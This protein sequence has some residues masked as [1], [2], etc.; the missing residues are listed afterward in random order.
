M[1]PIAFH[2]AS[3]D[4]FFSGSAFWF[5]AIVGQV[6]DSFWIKR[7]RRLAAILGTLLI[8]LSSTPIPMIPLLLFLLVG[9]SS[10]LLCSPNTTQK[11]IAV[12]T[13]LMISLFIVGSE[14]RYRF[15]WSVQEVSGNRLVIIG[16]SI[17]AGM[18]EPE[19]E[20]WPSLLA[21]QHKIE[22]TVLARPGATVESIMKAVQPFEHQP[23]LVLLEIG[24]NDVLQNGSH[25]KFSRGLQSLLKEVSIGGHRLVMVE[26]PLPP[27][28]NRFAETQRLLAK[29]F[30]VTLI[31]KRDFLAVLA[32]EGST[33]DSLHL[34]KLGHQRMAKMIWKHINPAFQ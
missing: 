23:S 5:L 29:Q 18:N 2:I 20:K 17:T 24:G 16:D 3:G 8:A 4:A 25:A 19:D 22:V 30:N 7:L 10:C 11:C 15:P 32:A 1:N 14:L 28:Y 6:F 33:S 34:S 26:L 21:A 13:W 27:F 31:P 12:T 9:V